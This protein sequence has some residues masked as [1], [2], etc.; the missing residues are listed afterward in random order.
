MTFAG[1]DDRM[2]ATSESRS[3]KL[4]CSPSEEP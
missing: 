4:C 3:V 1:S 2:Y